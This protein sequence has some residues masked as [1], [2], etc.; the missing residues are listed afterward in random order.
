MTN[1]NNNGLN[2][3]AGGTVD[4]PTEKHYIWNPRA[5]IFSKRDENEEKQE[6]QLTKKRQ[7]EDEKFADKIEMF[8]RVFFPFCYMLFNVFYWTNYLLAEDVPEESL[9]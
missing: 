9:A 6:E 4:L 2:I 1:R 7:E 3:Q 5:S 8:A